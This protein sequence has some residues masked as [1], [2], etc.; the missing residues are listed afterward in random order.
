LKIKENC[1]ICNI[2]AKKDKNAKQKN[3]KK[4]EFKKWNLQEMQLAT[5]VHYSHNYTSQI[6]KNFKIFII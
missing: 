2:S 1:E 5:V 6:F 4:M 3:C